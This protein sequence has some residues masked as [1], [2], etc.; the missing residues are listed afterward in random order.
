[1]RAQ[2]IRNTKLLNETDPAVRR[3][4]LDEMRALG[5]D[6]ARARAFLM[7]SSMIAGLRK[8]NALA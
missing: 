3:R 5:A 7:G 1:V 4:N 8:A 2:T 6:P